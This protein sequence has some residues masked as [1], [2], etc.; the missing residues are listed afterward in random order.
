MSLCPPS[1]DSLIH[2]RPFVLFWAARVCATVAMQMQAVAVG[3]Q[4]YDLTNSPLDLGLVGLAQF[5]PA[6]LLFLFTGHAADRYDRRTVL[7]ICQFVEGCAVAVLA[8]GTFA[9]WITRELILA[10][11]LV[12]GAARAFEAPALA[13]LLPTIVPPGLFPRAVAGSASANQFATIAGPAAG[14]LIYAANPV[15][16]YA[17]SSALFIAASILVALIPILT[18]VS[19]RGPF[20]IASLFAGFRFIWRHPIVLGA[21]SLDMFAV[22]LGGATALLPVFARDILH[23]DAQGLGLLRASPAVGAL[24][25]SLALAWWPMRRRVGPIMYACVAVF[26]VATIVFALSRSMALS[27]AALAVL[28]AVDLVSVVIRSTLVQLAT[29]DVMRGRVSAVNSLFIGTSNQL[30]EFRAGAMA[31]LIGAVPAALVGG[32]GTL[33]IVA[34]WIRL[35][36]P[37]FHVDEMQA[38]T[39]AAAPP[40]KSA[41]TGS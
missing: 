8:W 34:L 12:I 22:L 36:P 27:I 24:A 20:S 5:L 26:G 40:I 38:I 33:V 10:T 23:T 1:A 35:F 9:G 2:H 37:L 18:K 4:I 21:I 6:L 31:A 11:A 30:G 39:P 29:P 32:I 15:A 16:A 13:A 17:A 25:V 28:G 3:W 14:G 41:A 19:L 7:R